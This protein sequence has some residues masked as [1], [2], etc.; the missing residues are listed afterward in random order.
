M[1]QTSA[2][3]NKKRG[4]KNANPESEQLQVWSFK[5]NWLIY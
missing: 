3:S 1:Q 5:N 2:L 4:D